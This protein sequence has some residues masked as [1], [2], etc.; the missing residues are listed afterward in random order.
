MAL[1]VDAS[2]AV[3]WFVEENDSEAARRLLADDLPLIA[4]D[5]LVAEV[6]NAL[7]R[8]AR[9]GRINWRQFEASARVVGSMFSELRSSAVLVESA[10]RIARRLDHPIDDCSYLALA[11]LEET[12]V[13]TSDARLIAVTRGTRWSRRVE[14]LA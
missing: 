3:K 12:A 13:V 8:I 7:W 6:A 10:S 9:S 5:I 1:H 14:R 11:E 2:V 4:P